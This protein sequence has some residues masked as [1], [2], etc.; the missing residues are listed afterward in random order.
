MG[1][2]YLLGAT[3]R[4]CSAASPRRRRMC[5]MQA[6]CCSGPGRQAA[7]GASVATESSMLARLWLWQCV[8]QQQQQQQQR[9][10]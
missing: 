5:D 8:A 7:F 9:V 4:N 1:G 6:C 3:L 2:R 10:I